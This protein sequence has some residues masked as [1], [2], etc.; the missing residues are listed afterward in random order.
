M[1]NA[2]FFHRIAKTKG[3][4]NE[5][6]IGRYTNQSR[7]LLEVLDK[8]LNESGGPYLLGKEMTIADINTF[9]YVSIGTT[10]CEVA[11]LSSWSDFFELLFTGL[12]SLLGNGFSGRIGPFEDMD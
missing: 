10:V 1:G 4:V 12:D 2:M 11:P 7:G 8:Q 5:Y 9:T 6:S 3:E